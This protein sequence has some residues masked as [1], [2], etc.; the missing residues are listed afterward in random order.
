MHLDLLTGQYYNIGPFKDKIVNIN[1]KKGKHLIKAPI[2]KGKSF[3]FFDS[4]LFG[5]YKYSTRNILNRKSTSWYIKLIFSFGNKIFLIQRNLKATKSW[6]ESV[7]SKLWEVNISLDKFYSMIQNQPI[8]QIYPSLEKSSLQTSPLSSDLLSSKLSEIPFKSS[9]DLQNYLNQLLPPKEVFVSTFFMLQDSQNIFEMTPSNRIEIFKNIF[10][11]IWIDELKEKISDKKKEVNLQIKQLS[12]EQFWKNKFFS[13]LDQIQQI[14]ENL[15]I[16]IDI[17]DTIISDYQLF[18]DN[19]NLNTLSA[20]QLTNINLE[21]HLLEIEKKLNYITR[22]KTQLEEKQSQFK[23]TSHQ[24]KKIEKEIQEISLQISKLQKE[25]SNYDENKLQSLKNQKKQLQDTL[26][27]IKQQTLTSQILTQFSSIK[28]IISI[29]KNIDL[30]QLKNII[31]Q[32]ISLWKTLSK[33]KESIENQI[34]TIQKEYQLLLTKLENWEL[35]PW[36]IAYE[37]LQNAINQEKHKIQSHVQKIE[38]EIENTIQLQQQLKKQLKEIQDHIK[39]LSTQI[40]RQTTFKCELINKNCPFVEKIKWDSLFTI[41]TQLENFKKQQK[42]ILEQLKQLESNLN[43]LQQQKTEYQ[44]ELKNIDGQKLPIYQEILK[45]KYQ[46]EQEIKK[47]N[48][49]NKTQNLQKQIE[50]LDNKI[51]LLRNVLKNINYQNILQNYQQYIKIEKDF[52]YI[53]KEIQNLEHL[54]QKIN[55]K[56]QQIASLDWQ[57]QKLK[58]HQKELNT[59]LQE[60]NINIQK[61]ENTLQH[62]NEKLLINQKK[63]LNQL[64]QY[65]HKLIDLISEYNNSKIEIE[66]LKEKEKIYQNLQNILWKELMIVVLQEFLPILEEVINWLLSQVVDYNVIFQPI[67]TKAGKLE[68]EIYAEDEKWI[69]PIKSLS[70]GQKTVLKLAWILAVSVIMKNKFLFLDETI[71]NLDFESVWKVAKMIEDFI[72]KNNL[73]F[74]V[75]S[76]SQQ[77]QQMNIWDEIITI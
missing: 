9:S 31:D 37:K 76:H 46:I 1:F 21:K 41:K 56:K 7:Q 45:Q 11:L 61:L 63:Y 50:K 18:K 71:N 33:E 36:T 22:I 68:L 30:H 54:W 43:K 2:W 57:L 64:E 14:Y 24:I 40:E 20:E 34:K 4:P 47:F 65:L 67:E 29:P 59:V 17:L 39:S 13:I 75:V 51:Q 60:I 23:Q 10:W 44:Q 72:K 12:S 73:K 8:L 3:L 28:E 16:K 69:R 55:E 19:F 5:L 74:Y 49:E 58:N 70:G 6:N 48:L 27:K 66:K 26:T 53:D 42:N 15:G 52:L 32:I 25:I 38:S 35:K 62:Q 77:I